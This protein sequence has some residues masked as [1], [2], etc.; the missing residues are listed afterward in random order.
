MQKEEERKKRQRENHS[1]L[2]HIKTR[3][4]KTITLDFKPNDSIEN[5]KAKI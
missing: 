5:M 3:T 1:L 4:G 2:I